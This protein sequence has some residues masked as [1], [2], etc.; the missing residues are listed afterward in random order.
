V[1]YDHRIRLLR[2]LNGSPAQLFARWR[3]GGIKLFVIR[4]LLEARR[5]HPSLF[6]EGSYE[7]VSVL[8]EFACHCLAFMRRCEGRSMLV[9]VPRLCSRVGA[10]PVGP[11]WEDTRLAI[12]ENPA[13]WRNILSGQAHEGD[14]LLSLL[15]GEMPLA[16]LIA[17]T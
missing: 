5:Q 7:P 11:A 8:G 10:S 1:D 14:L 15:L 13:R 12:P 17:E 2:R 4:K 16:V 6:R 3:D 9:V